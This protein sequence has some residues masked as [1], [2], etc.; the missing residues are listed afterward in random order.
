LFF[1]FCFFFFDKASDTAIEIPKVSSIR[2]HHDLRKTVAALRDAKTPAFEKR[3]ISKTGAVLA[4][5]DDPEWKPDYS[6]DGQPI[7]IDHGHSE[8]PNGVAAEEDEDEWVEGEYE[9]VEGEV[10][11]EGEDG[12]GEEGYEYEEESNEAGGNRVQVT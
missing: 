1:V 5:L 12:Y 11:Y 3:W 4:R 10:G 6:H 7:I 2:V 8:A 9:Y